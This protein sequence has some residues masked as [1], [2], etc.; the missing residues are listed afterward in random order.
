MQYKKQ[1]ANGPFDFNKWEYKVPY[2]DL[3]EEWFIE[4]IFGSSS[5]KV[6]RMNFVKKLSKQGKLDFFFTSAKLRKKYK[7]FQEKYNK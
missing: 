6:T 5:A 4:P 2:S 1:L 3:F 7:S